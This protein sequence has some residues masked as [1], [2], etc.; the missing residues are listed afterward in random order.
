MEKLFFVKLLILLCLICMILL[1]GRKINEQFQDEKP[2]TVRLSVDTNKSRQKLILNWN[3]S[4]EDI[5][6]FYIIYYVNNDGP[7]IITLPN[8]DV[9][10]KE[11][12]NFTYEYLDVKL[13]VDYKFA[14]LASNGRS[15]S[16]ID[17]FV[18]AK[19]TPP[20]LQVEYVNDAIT[21]IIC[22][23]D[24]SHTITNARKCQTEQDIIEAKSIEYDQ[25][26]TFKYKSLDHDAHDELMRNLNHETKIKLNFS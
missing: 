18:K 26:G 24:G 9:S 5:T 16:S 17:K 4:R 11:N 2:P 20:G 14:V 25:D 19:L 1:V 21:K 13:N 12:D 22:N 7:F 8:L 15:L 6:E 10:N 23:S 3:K